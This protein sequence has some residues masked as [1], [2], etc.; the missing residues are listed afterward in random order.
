MELM[1]ILIQMK[2][3]LFI[4]LIFNLSCNK[5]QEINRFA[6]ALD[7]TDLVRVDNSNFPY[8]IEEEDSVFHL[9]ILQSGC[10]NCYFE[11][12]S[13]MQSNYKLPSLSFFILKDDSFIDADY[14]IN[15]K[16][17]FKYPVFLISATKF[18]EV[19]IGEY[20]GKLERDQ[21]VLYK[22]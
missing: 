20:T 6:Y 12:D 7:L 13:F 19:N 18:P 21:L 17:N 8:D 9:K 1:L 2:K 14:M 15:E 5:N 22:D 10:S 11:L 16:L 4:L 3:L